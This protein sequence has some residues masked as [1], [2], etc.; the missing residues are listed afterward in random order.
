MK[1]SVNFD[2]F[3]LQDDEC[4]LMYSPNFNY[5]EK[6]SLTL[7]YHQSYA[8]WLFAFEGCSKQRKDWPFYVEAWKVKSKPFPKLVFA[9]LHNT[10]VFYIDQVHLL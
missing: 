8:L 10:L 6:Y 4:L 1:N 9:N 3:F 2:D 5:I 7:A